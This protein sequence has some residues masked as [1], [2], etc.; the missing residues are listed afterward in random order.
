MSIK[1]LNK[2][3]VSK[4]HTN[5][6]V[7]FLVMFIM[8]MF[9]FSGCVTVG[10]DF[11]VLDVSKIKIGVTNQE[12]IQTMFGP[13]WRVGIEDG[14]RT[15]TYGKYKYTISG[16]KNAH[17]LVI[18]FNEKNIVSSYSFNTTQ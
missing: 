4:G 3:F 16:Q 9:L 18:R 1:N 10:R 12:E 11:S 2:L 15:W 13:P 8:I 5:T 7:I 17:D 6:A 14:Q